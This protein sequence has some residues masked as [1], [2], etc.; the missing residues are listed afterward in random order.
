MG[1]NKKPDVPGTY[2]GAPTCKFKRDGKVCGRQAFNWLHLVVMIMERETKVRVAFCDE[3]FK[4]VSGNASYS[5]SGAQ[6][7]SD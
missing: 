1:F 2:K 7:V 5:I 3:C 4:E 6:P